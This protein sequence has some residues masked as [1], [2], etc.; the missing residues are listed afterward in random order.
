MRS[1]SHARLL[2]IDSIFV[3]SVRKALDEQ[4][5][6]RRRGPALEVELDLIGDRP[7][8][9]TDP[10]APLLLRAM[11]V[12]RHFGDEPVL[13]RSS[14]DS[15]VPIA[16]GIPAVTISRGGIG[17]GAHSPDEWWINHNGPRAIQRALLLILSEAGY[18]GG[19]TASQ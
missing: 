6:V 19:G 8:G 1:E 18:T 16:L 2:E 5:A 4:N 13:E 10:N 7:S 3:A 9:E 17:G 15:N 12:T 14:T 11:A